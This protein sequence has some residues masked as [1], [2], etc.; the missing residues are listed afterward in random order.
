[1]NK[2]IFLLMFGVILLVGIISYASANIDVNVNPYKSDLTVADSGGSPN[3]MKIIAAT[4]GKL[5][6]IGFMAGDTAQ[7][8]ILYDATFSTQ[9]ASALVING[10]ATLNYQLVAGTTYYVVGNQTGNRI[11]GTGIESYPVNTVDLNWTA[12]R[13]GSGDEPA[14]AFSISNVT[15]DTGSTVEV[16]TLNSPLNNT[17]I[18]IINNQSINFQSVYNISSTLFNWTSANTTIW[19]ANNN[20][21]FNATNI[22]ITGQNNKTAIQVNNFPIGTF[23]WNSIACYKNS[24]FANCT[25][26]PSNNTFSTINFNI[27]GTNYNSSSYETKSETFFFN[28]SS[29]V[30]ISNPTFVYNSTNYSAILGVVNSTFF[31]ISS[32]IDVPLGVGINNFYFT[33]MTNTSNTQSQTFNQTVGALNFTNC[34]SPPTYLNF[35]FADELNQSQLNASIPASTFNY[36]LGSGSV[37]K[38]LLYSNSALNYNYGFCLTPSNL[39]LNLNYSISDA[40]PNYLTR[41]VIEPNFQATNASVNRIL[42][43]LQTSSGQIVTFQVVNQA[44]QPLSGVL[45]NA[46]RII[47]G[48]TTEVGTGVSGSDGGISFFV[49]PLLTYTFTFSKSGFSNVIFTTTPSQS[50]YTITMGGGNNQAAVDYTRGITQTI[51]PP[52]DILNNNTVYNFNYTLNSSYWTATSWGYTLYGNSTILITSNSSTVGSGGTV[53]SSVNT[54]SY[55]TIT[56]NYFYVINGT[57]TNSSITWY[58][59]SLGNTSYSILNFF[60][61]LK[62][63][64]TLGMFGITPFTVG[65]IIFFVILIAT[66]LAHFKFGFSGE[67]SIIAIV[68]GLVILFDVGL[69]FDNFMNPTAAAIPYLPSVVMVLIAAV[70]ILREST[71]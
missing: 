42:Y 5:V 45:G 20:S 58:V 55:S 2:K 40:N 10:V 60:T 44:Q 35:T 25:Y 63:Y 32:T 64:I 4:G 71:R 33:W 39:T 67:G 14:N 56:M 47:N 31:N 51:L 8:G 19:Y 28:I 15:I 17:A 18:S 57:T 13:S 27:T 59:S 68:T 53:S 65:L 16:V 37:T 29:S 9:L 50:Q 46:T 24:T 34:A 22:T 41:T 49:D 11:R 61:D 43:L 1:M 21:I 66:G 23:Y 36:W 69:G 3:G 12:G 7:Y 48:V 70:T 26:A 62:S 30:A 6:S 38:Q 54:S 52:V